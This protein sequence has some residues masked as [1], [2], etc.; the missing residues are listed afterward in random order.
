MPAT[1]PTETRPHP[2]VHVYVFPPDGCVVVA[3]QT[4]SG[5][6]CRSTRRD[7]HNHNYPRSSFSK[8]RSWFE[9]TTHV[10]Q[11]REAAK[12]HLEA[13][14][15]AHCYLWPPGEAAERVL[16]HLEHGW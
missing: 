15:D 2:R 12:V 7:E 13:C 5:W 1:T 9:D 10:T 16:Q 6:R 11:D 4:R 14:E 3:T 8:V